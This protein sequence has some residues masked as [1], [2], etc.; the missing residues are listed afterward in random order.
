MSEAV[1]RARQAVSDGA[2]NHELLALCADTIE[3]LTAEVERLKARVLR[4][5]DTSVKTALELDAVRAEVARL[6]AENERL[7]HHVD[8]PD[9]TILGEPKK[10]WSW[11]RYS[12]ARIDKLQAENARLTAEVERRGLSRFWT[13]FAKMEAERDA[14]RA[15][16]E[17]IRIVTTLCVE[18]IE[19]GDGD[20]RCGWHPMTERQS[21]LVHR[22]RTALEGT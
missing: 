21:E 6:T 4:Q 12:L 15:R 17:E 14:A 11:K 10:G 16:I 9:G 18:E 13:M 3:S 2:A 20:H 19:R 1:Q 7:T 8:D 22:A 5:A